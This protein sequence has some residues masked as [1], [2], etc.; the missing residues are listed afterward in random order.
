MRENN[1]TALSDSKEPPI[2][3]NYAAF[4]ASAD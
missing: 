4:I 3:Y 1:K 2:G